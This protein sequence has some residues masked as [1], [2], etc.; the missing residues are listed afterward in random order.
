MSNISKGCK[1]WI[2]ISHRLKFGFCAQ[3]ILWFDSILF[4]GEKF[5]LIGPQIGSFVFLDW[6]F[7]FEGKMQKVGPAA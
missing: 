3:S 2:N 5:L 6:N 7:A 4:A 1:I